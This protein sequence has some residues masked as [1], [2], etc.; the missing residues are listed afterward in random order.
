LYHYC[1]YNN[2]IIIMQFS[3]SFL[4]VVVGLYFCS[5]VDGAN[6]F[7]DLQLPHPPIGIWDYIVVGGGTAGSVVATR[8]AQSGKE[9][10]LIEAGGP[11]QTVL[12]GTDYVAASYT[13][14]ADGTTTFHTPLTRYD[15]PAFAPSAYPTSAANP[16]V[17]YPVNDIYGYSTPHGKVLGGNGVHNN[18]CWTRSTQ[19]TLNAWNVT[20]WNYT[21]LLPYFKKTE[22]VSNTYLAS[23]TAYHGTS[24]PVQLNFA[25]PGGEDQAGPAWVQSCINAGYPNNTDFNGP[26]RYGCGYHVFNINSKGIR[27]SSAASYL[28]LV[29]QQKNF[30][31]L[32]HSLATKV[33]FTRDKTAYGVVVN[34]DGNNYTA[35]ASR[36]IVLS[37]GAIN[38]PKLLML[39]GI[40]L[41][42]ILDPLG[43]PVISNL[44]VGTKM[45][46]HGD[47][48]VRYS[49]PQVDY[50]A[51]YDISSSSTSYAQFGTG[52]LASP[53]FF[54]TAFVKSNDSL[55]EPDLLLGTELA[56]GFP[57][58]IAIQLSIHQPVPTLGFL[59]ISSTD[60]NAPPYLYLNTWDSPVNV[61]KAVTGIRIIR[62]IMS[63]SPATTLFGNETLPGPTYQTDD[64]LAAYVK[65][66]TG[67]TKTSHLWGGARLGN[68]GDNTAVLDPRARVKGVTG[69]RVCDL[70]IVPGICGGHPNANVIMFGEKIAD[71]IIQDNT[72]N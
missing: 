25:A 47:V 48:T 57:R 8:L 33:L 12:G 71:M 59:N 1:L 10:L 40:G 58:Q 11:S 62:H 51:V 53:A 3:T 35:L 55:A 7:P 26:T 68:D 24:G 23:N 17:G 31:I 43:I 4:V 32:L 9:V 29:L 15:V 65:T 64:E 34:I 6:N 41:P 67:G 20:G 45:L 36:E 49:Y 2:C 54:G 46:S 18:M 50:P 28:P 72:S 14:N 16:T 5:Y 27:A 44:P 70:S 60:I 42:S 63:L 21:D 13:K 22:N 38:G 30:K 19:G 39:S 69:L 37:L 61:Q 52:P 66:N 56:S